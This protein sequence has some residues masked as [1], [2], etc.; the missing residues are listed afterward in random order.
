MA[1]KGI[2]GILAG[3]AAGMAVKTVC[4]RAMSKKKSNDV[5]GECSETEKLEDAEESSDEE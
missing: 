3:I 2:I 5:E 1:K 4:D